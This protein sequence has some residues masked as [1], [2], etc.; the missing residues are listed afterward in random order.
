MNEESDATETHYDGSLDERELAVLTE[1][2]R[3]EESLVS[4][5]GLRRRLELH[6]QSL[7]RTLK[8]L[9]RDGFITRNETGY[10]IT[11]DGNDA[12]HLTD[13][14]YVSGN[15]LTIFETILPPHLRPENVVAQLSRRWFR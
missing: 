11:G 4:F 2:G 1:L 14:A 5:Q 10:K 3:E 8:R 12:I 9:V 7:N 13:S 6:Q 15:V